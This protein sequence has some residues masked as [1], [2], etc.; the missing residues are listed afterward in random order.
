MLLVFLLATPGAY[1]QILERDQVAIRAV[2]SEVDVNDHPFNRVGLT[3]TQVA[4]FLASQHT[5]TFAGAANDKRR[6]GEELFDL[7]NKS[8]YRQ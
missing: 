1:R 6:R 7:R 8:W 4:H 3:I 5:R 2:A